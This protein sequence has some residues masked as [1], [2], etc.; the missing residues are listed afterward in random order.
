VEI[1]L[2]ALEFEAESVLAP[3]IRGS[4][5]PNAAGAGAFE[6]VGA[7]IAEEICRLACVMA[8][9]GFSS[10][11]G[12]GF[13]ACANPVGIVADCSPTCDG[14]V[15]GFAEK[16]LAAS[17]LDAESNVEF[18]VEFDVELNVELD[19]DTSQGSDD[20]PKFDSGG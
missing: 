13:C 5:R 2:R 18:D 12:A 4:V 10:A 11:A 14:F 17:S 6:I 9:N 1:D 8:K 15:D 16:R 19:A 7:D 20:V 3:A